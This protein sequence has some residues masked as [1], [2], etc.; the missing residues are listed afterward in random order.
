MSPAPGVVHLRN[1]SKLLCRTLIRSRFTDQSGVRIHYLEHDLEVAGADTGG[2]VG[3]SE[4]PVVFVPGMTDTAEDYAEVLPL[5]GRR[6]VV[7]DLRGHGRSE[8]PP[9]GSSLI[10]HDLTAL[11]GDVGAVIDA[12]TAG[13]VHLV[14]FSR[15]TSAAIAWALRYPDRVRSL[16]IGDYAPEERVVPDDAVR[17]LLNGRWRGTPVRERLDVPAAR[18]MFRAARNR[19]FWEALARMRLPLLVVRSH[20]SALID[21]QRWARY[22]RTFPTAR[23]IEFPDSPHDIFRPDRGRFP[24]LVRDHADWADRAYHSFGVGLTGDDLPG[25]GAA[26]DR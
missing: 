22:H 26:V 12:V 3:T 5:F 20:H 16:A 6:A 2:P 24:R 1:A 25:H 7:P 4:A 19:S 23:L 17:H 14:T 18:Q 11:C 15:G 13:P 21:D 10:D 9:P 8:A